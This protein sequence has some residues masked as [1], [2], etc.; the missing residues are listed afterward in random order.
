[1][2]Q[3]RKEAINQSIQPIQKIKQS[4]YERQ[5]LLS[6]SWNGNNYMGSNREMSNNAIAILKMAF[7]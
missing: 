6:Q 5:L 1:M 3:Y 2:K 4:D 7:R